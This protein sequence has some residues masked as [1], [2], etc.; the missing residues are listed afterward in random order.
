MRKKNIKR[1]LKFIPSRKLRDKV[2]LMFI[3]KMYK[4]NSVT[5]QP[6]DFF[7][8]NLTIKGQGNKIN[9]DSFRCGAAS[10]SIC[11]DSNEVTICQNTEATIFATIFGSSSRL[12]IGEALAGMVHIM[13]GSS[14][15]SEKAVTNCKVQI[16]NFNTCGET[17]FTLIQS[18]TSITTGDDCMFSFDTHLYNSD[19]HAIRDYDSGKLLNPAHDIKIGNHVWLGWGAAVM[20]NVT[21][22]D[23][24]VIGRGSI[25][26]KSITESNCC[27]AGSPC[28]II[29]KN[30][31]WLRGPDDEFLDNL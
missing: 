23:G 7:R 16:G 30:I 14:W 3:A 17:R 15:R 27:A 19:G 13:I 5:M 18:N 8:I 9:I 29:R 11:G 10:I 21:I 26:V 31:Q 28:S 20:K 4:G 1:L 25:V 6:S 22:A 12:Q 24:C 2:L